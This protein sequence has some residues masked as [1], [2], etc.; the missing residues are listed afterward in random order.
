MELGVKIDFLDLITLFLALFA[1]VVTRTGNLQSATKSPPSPVMGHKS[2]SRQSYKKGNN[3]S[4]YVTEG[5]LPLPFGKPTKQ[6]TC[7]I[8]IMVHD[9]FR[10][11]F[12]HRRVFLVSYDWG[13]MQSCAIDM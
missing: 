10:I 13:G 6:S 3:A 7:K 2:S 5:N 4:L 12:Y 9:V 1:A 11:V 8:D